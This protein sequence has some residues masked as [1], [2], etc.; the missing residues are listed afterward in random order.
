MM[1]KKKANSSSS[2]S[3]VNVKNVVEIFNSIDGYYE[4]LNVNR[5]ADVKTLKSA[6][7]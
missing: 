1:K 6:Y 3:S 2:S 7:R 4:L 5:N